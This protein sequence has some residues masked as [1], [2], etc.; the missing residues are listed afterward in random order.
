MRDRAAKEAFENETEIKYFVSD[1]NNPFI[2]VVPK[3][4]SADY[5]GSAEEVPRGSVDTFL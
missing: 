2:S 5:K 3:V 1:G 4:C